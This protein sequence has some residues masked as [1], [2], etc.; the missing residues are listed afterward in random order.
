MPQMRMNSLKSLAM[1]CGP[2]SEM[3]R[4]AERGQPGYQKGAAAATRMKRIAD[5]DEIIGTALYLA[6]DASSFVT[7]EDL[8]VT[9]GMHL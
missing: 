2:L 1:N 7:G 8:K 3:M 6:S 4:G 9:G 5:C